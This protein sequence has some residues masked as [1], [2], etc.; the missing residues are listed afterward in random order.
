MI[1]NPPRKWLRPADLFPH[2]RQFLP[3]VFRAAHKDGDWLFLGRHRVGP[4]MA[5]PAACF[6][7]AAAPPGGGG[8]QASPGLWSPQWPPWI[9]A[10][11]RQAGPQHPAPSPGD[12]SLPL[13]APRRR[14][15]ASGGACSRRPRGWK[16]A[17]AAENGTEEIS[18]GPPSRAHRS[19]GSGRLPFALREQWKA[20][21]AL[22]SPQPPI[23]VSAPRKGP[24]GRATTKLCLGSSERHPVKLGE[25]PDPSPS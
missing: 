10:E 7:R 12:T 8:G 6:F 9:R 22:L 17:R 18:P 2:P 23:R 20:G 25:V 15:A 4:E 19:T 1:A 11:A 13:A 5:S 16:G 3:A 24:P 14:W 21:P